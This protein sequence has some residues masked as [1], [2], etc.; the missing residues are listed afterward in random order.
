MVPVLIEVYL[1]EELSHHITALSTLIP[2]ILD[3][4]TYLKIL[5][6]R[7]LC[8]HPAHSC[9]G[10]FMKK[11]LLREET[12]RLY[13][14]YLFGLYCLYLRSYGIETEVK[15]KIPAATPQKHYSSCAWRDFE[16]LNGPVLRL[17]VDP[18]AFFAP[19]GWCS[20]WSPPSDLSP[21][22]ARAGVG[23]GRLSS[24]S[25]LSWERLTSALQFT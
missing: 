1:F 9:Q 24:S 21:L 23:M 14:L 18:C 12:N 13:R 5:S 19:S 22:V 10:S 2:F 17:R 4:R 8:T 15:S 7:M 11:Y 3:E 16:I 20:P 6:F 25:I